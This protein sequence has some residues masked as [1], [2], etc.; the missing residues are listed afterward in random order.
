MISIT[1]GIA[2]WRWLDFRYNPPTIRKERAKWKWTIF[3]ST[4]LI[5]T[6]FLF[7]FYFRVPGGQSSRIFR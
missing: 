6:G 5:V 4:T 3:P 2:P 7:K 1:I